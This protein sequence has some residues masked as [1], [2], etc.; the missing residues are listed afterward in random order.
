MRI[1]RIDP[2]QQQD[3]QELLR[4]RQACGWGS[5][6]VDRKLQD[7]A[8]GKLLGAIDLDTSYFGEDMSCA[9][10]RTFS[11]IGVFI[12]AEYGLSMSGIAHS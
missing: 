7:C 5:E 3:R 4:H 8:D 10:M 9:E 2:L 12:F 1:R 6:N 11:I